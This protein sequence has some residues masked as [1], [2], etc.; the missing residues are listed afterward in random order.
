MK[1]LAGE[2]V[3]RR[4]GGGG[5]WGGGIAIKLLMARINQEMAANNKAMIEK[6]SVWGN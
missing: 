3:K 5:G 1:R 6:E 2:E 4:P